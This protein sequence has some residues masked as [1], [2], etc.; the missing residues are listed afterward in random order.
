VVYR[1]FPSAPAW[2]RI[3]ASL[4]EGVIL[5]TTGYG[6]LDQTLIYSETEEFEF[7]PDISQG[8]R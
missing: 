4:K 6:R 7:E 5:L 8:G 2:G 1:V 3:I